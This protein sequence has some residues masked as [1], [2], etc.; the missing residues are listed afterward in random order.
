MQ[1]MTIETLHETF[2]RNLPELEIMALARFTHLDPEARAEAIQNATALTWK[3]WVRHA[4]KGRPTDETMLRNV[5][6]FAI[7]QT[8]DGRTITR[9]DGKRGKGRQDTYDRPDGTTVKRIDFNMFV[10]DTTPIP[11]QVAF[12]LDFPLFM[13]TSNERQ[14]GMAADLASGMGTGEVAKKY[15]VSAGAVSQFRTRFKVLLER[16]YGEAA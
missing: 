12:R 3:Y 11:D 1:E 4:E 13:A 9:G 8:R 6:W 10:H 5:W 7:K 16:F 15:G 2:V 14:R